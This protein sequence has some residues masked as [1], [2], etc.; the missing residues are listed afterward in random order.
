ME[1]IKAHYLEWLLGAAIAV[2][3]ICA[4]TFFHNL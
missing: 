1:T 4:I 3:F 2:A